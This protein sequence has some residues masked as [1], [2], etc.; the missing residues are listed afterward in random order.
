MGTG[1]CTRFATRIVS[2][3]TAPGTPNRFKI[4]IIEP[5]VKVEGFVYPLDNDYKD[6]VHMGETLSAD[7]FEVVM[8]EVSILPVYIICK[9]LT[10]S[11]GFK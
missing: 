10:S 2:K 4:T 6:Y 5:E 7:E 3:R 1:C 8:N 11:I 9:T